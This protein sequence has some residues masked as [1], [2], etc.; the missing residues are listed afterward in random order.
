MFYINKPLY[1]SIAEHFRKLSKVRTG[2]FYKPKSDLENW[3]SNNGK[4]WKLLGAPWDVNLLMDGYAQFEP[5]LFSEFKKEYDKLYSPEFTLAFNSFSPILGVNKTNQH[6]GPPIYDL[7][8]KTEKIDGL[9]YQ[10]DKEPERGD[11]WIGIRL[12]LTNDAAKLVKLFSLIKSLVDSFPMPYTYNYSDKLVCCDVVFFAT[13]EQNRKS[14]LELLQNKLKEQGSKYDEASKFWKFRFEPVKPA[15]GNIYS[16]TV[17][18]E[19]S[20]TVS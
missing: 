19:R 13:C 20:D 9:R 8:I 3:G 17:H 12:E 1:E 6:A 7:A 11:F 14:D 18:A 4:V 5:N 10:G 16:L 2:F 15:S